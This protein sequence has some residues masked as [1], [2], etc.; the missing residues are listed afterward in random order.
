MQISITGHHVEVTDGLKSAVHHTLDKIIK[1][2]PDVDSLNVILRVEKNEQIAEV[3]A[4]ILGQDLVA[5][6]S[7]HDLY[8]SISDLKM[9]LEALLQKRKSTVKAH[10]HAKPEITEEE[11]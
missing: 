5:T 11:V 7:S 4:H 2:Y 3:K 9:K 6:A 10:P 1:H 8:T